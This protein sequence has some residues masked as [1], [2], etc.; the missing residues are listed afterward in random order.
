[1]KAGEANVAQG[2]HQTKARD[3]SKIHPVEQHQMA[4]VTPA[5]VENVLVSGRHTH[6]LSARAT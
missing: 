1:M 2:R 6:H 5:W 3:T 4:L